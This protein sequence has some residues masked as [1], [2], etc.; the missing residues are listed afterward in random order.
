MLQFNGRATLV[1]LLLPNLPAKNSEVVRSCLQCHW[2]DAASTTSPNEP[3]SFDGKTSLV[4]SELEYPSLTLNANSLFIRMWIVEMSLP[5]IFRTSVIKA[6]IS[7]SQAPG[8]S[9]MRLQESHPMLF[10]FWRRIGLG[11]ILT[12]TLLHSRPTPMST[13]SRY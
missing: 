6:E 10:G 3:T 2:E 7:V 11:K 9:I 8:R 5:F 13:R 1:S 12:C 4:S